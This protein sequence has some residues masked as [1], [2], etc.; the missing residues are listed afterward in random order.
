MIAVHA[1]GRA[2]R[3][4]RSSSPQ[5]TGYYAHAETVIAQAALAT[6]YLAGRDLGV[7]RSRPARAA[8]ARAAARSADRGPP[9]MRRDAEARVGVDV[10]GT[11]TKAVAVDLATGGSSPERCCR[12]RTTPPRAS[13]PASCAASREVAERSAPTRSSWS[14][15]R[16]RRRSTRCSRATSAPV[17][18][19]RARAA[20]RICA[21]RASARALDRVELSPGQAPGD[22]ARVP[23]RHRRPRPDERAPPRSRGCARPACP[24]RASP[25]RSRPTTTANETGRRR[26]RARSRAAGLRVERAVRLYGLELRAVT[27]AIN[28]SILPIA[29]AHRRL[30]RGGRRG[31]RHR[32]AR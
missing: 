7:R 13:P 15:T 5:A 26:W 10:G 21:R 14:P 4:C 32:A 23:R 9:R 27:A 30:R 28:A 2:G 6:V 24:R 31:G 11:F 25:R 1:P 16:R 3:A 18:V 20:G 8:L 22:R 17:G 12:R 29:I 19:H